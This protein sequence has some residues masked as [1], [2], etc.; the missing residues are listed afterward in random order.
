MP[1]HR[2]FAAL[3]SFVA[4]LRRAA[5]RLAPSGR[6]SPG[7]DSY[8][9]ESRAL[10]AMGI[11]SQSLPSPPS[12]ASQRPCVPHGFSATRS[13]GGISCARQMGP[14]AFASLLEKRR[15]H[16]PSCANPPVP[17]AAKKSAR[18]LRPCEDGSGCDG[19]EP[20][21]APC[22]CRKGSA[23]TRG[24]CVL[25]VFWAAGRGPFPCSDPPGTMDLC[26]EN[27]KI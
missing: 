13:C 16:L 18:P 17:L 9:I 5:A 21:H 7:G 3:G 24:R 27:N 11:L 26:Q 15:P 12:P 19:S 6:Q 25:V 20:P 22:P 23:A 8:A 4:K 2:G 1:G 10:R 14:A